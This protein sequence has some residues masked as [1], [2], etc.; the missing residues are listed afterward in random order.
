LFSDKHRIHVEIEGGS[1][2][3][4]SAMLTVDN[5]DEMQEVGCLALTN[6]TANGKY[7]TSMSLKYI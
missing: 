3:V 1:K 4:V 5:C 6:I 2:A 7:A